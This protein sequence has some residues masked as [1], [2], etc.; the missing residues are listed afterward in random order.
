[1]AGN[2]STLLA[3]LSLRVTALEALLGCATEQPI[4]PAN[5][6]RLTKRQLAQRQ[7]KSTRTIDRDVE[8]GVLPAPVVENGRCFWWISDLQRH[9]LE[10]G[11]SYKQETA[12]R[13][14]RSCPT[15]KITAATA[16]T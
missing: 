13:R 11:A 3:T 9:E 12:R 7:G 4:D 16:T 14:S 10:R 5:D 1:M 6:R 15:R 8:R 2:F